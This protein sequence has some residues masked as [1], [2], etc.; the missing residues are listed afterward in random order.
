MGTQ[1]FKESPPGH[2]GQWTCLLS[3]EPTELAGLEGGAVLRICLYPVRI[4]IAAVLC[5]PQ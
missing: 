5:C 1:I 2:A 4:L 3:H